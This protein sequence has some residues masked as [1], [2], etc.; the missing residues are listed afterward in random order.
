MVSARGH[1]RPGRGV[2]ERLF[3]DVRYP[4][5]ASGVGGSDMASEN[6]D[7]ALR[8]RGTSGEIEVPMFAVPRERDSLVIRRNDAE[9]TVEH[10]RARTSYTYQFEALAHAVRHRGPVLTD[11]DWSGR[12]MR[13]VDAAYA[14]AG[15]DRRPPHA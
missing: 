12:P 2:D 14:A 10:L 8:V 9:E 11:A 4:S 7:M 13:L 5:G 6:R 3:V 15:M 1:E